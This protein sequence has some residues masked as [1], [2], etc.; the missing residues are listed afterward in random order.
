MAKPKQPNVS[1]N[2]KQQPDLEKRKLALEW[3]LRGYSYEAIGKELEISA[4]RA[5]TLVSEGLAQKKAEYEDSASQSL[6]F[7]LDRIERMI[8][9]LEK[10]IFAY[11]AVVKDEWV[12]V[13]DEKTGEVTGKERVQ[14][15]LPK[16]VLDALFMADKLLDRKAKLLGFFRT[17]DTKQKEPLP[18]NDDD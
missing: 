13:V 9:Q 15:K 4:S 7:E 16:Q 10:V 17:D 1:K 2:S 3:R 6:Q 8:V 11:D 12:D 5:Y 14:P 18:W